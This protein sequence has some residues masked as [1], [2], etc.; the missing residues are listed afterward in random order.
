[1]FSILKIQKSSSNINLGFS[2]I[3]RKMYTETTHTRE[4]K[5][6]VFFTCSLQENTC[7]CKV[8]CPDKHT[9]NDQG[10]LR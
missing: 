7:L 6:Y 1:M 3:A 8:Y 10:Q 5:I 4:Y 2:E 9:H